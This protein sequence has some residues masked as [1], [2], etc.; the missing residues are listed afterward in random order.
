MSNNLDYKTVQECNTCHNIL[1]NCPA[2]KLYW[3]SSYNSKFLSESIA[4]QNNINTS[5]DFN[6]FIANS[7]NQ[8]LINN[9]NKYNSCK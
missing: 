5:Y 8:L 1:P 3:Q 6:K 7:N 4:K 9:L 2:I